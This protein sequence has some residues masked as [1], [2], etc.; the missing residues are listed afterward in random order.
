MHMLEHEICNGC[1]STYLT[2]RIMKESTIT[3]I[4]PAENCSHVI[5]YN[6]IKEYAGV[7]VFSKYKQ[8][9]TQSNN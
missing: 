2:T 6:E 4:C 7:K 3:I 5:D 8:S 1:V 9:L